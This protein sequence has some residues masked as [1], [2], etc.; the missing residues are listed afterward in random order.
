MG[1]NNLSE[2]S[3]AVW[4]KWIDVTRSRCHLHFILNGGEIASHVDCC[5]KSAG[6][7]IKRVVL[8]LPDDFKPKRVLEVGASVGFNCLALAAHYKE[9]EVYSVEPDE[10]AVEVAKSMAQD[11]ELNYIPTVGVGEVMGYPDGFFDLIV[12]HTVIEHVKNVESTVK[13]MTRVLSTNG[14]VHLE[15][16]NYLWPYEPHL[17]VWCVPLLGKKSVR[18]LSFLQGKHKDNWYVEHLRFVTPGKLEKLFSV[19]ELAWENRSEAKLRN[20]ANGTADIKM[21]GFASSVIAFFGR[22]GISKIL[23]SVI[24]KLRLY[25]SVLYTLRK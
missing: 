1:T 9:A 23:V 5:S 13:E 17:D 20:A 24:G 22:F 7:T 15:A 21:Y 12:C 3:I 18:L 8:D 14:F 19:N 16:P 10:D 25:P 4:K 11:Y 2:S 6:E